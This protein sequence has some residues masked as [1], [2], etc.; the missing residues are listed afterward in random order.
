M[1]IF[2]P[3]GE[4]A[5]SSYGLA[6][7]AILEGSKAFFEIPQRHILVWTIIQMVRGSEAI[8]LHR[9]RF[10]RESIILEEHIRRNFQPWFSYSFL[11]QQEIEV[12]CTQLSRG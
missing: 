11:V 4:P 7:Q 12:S 9:C 5:E 10:G 6:Y 2:V 1:T 3:C 8:G